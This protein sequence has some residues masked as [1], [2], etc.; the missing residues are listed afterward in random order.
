M[1]TNTS[2]EDNVPVSFDCSFCFVV[3]NLTQSSVILKERTSFEKTVPPD[4]LEA[5]S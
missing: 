3:V 4:Y 2:D 1:K 5:F